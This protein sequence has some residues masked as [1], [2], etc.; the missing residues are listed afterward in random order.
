MPRI[1]AW[2]N[3]HPRQVVNLVSNKSQKWKS[4]AEKY[5]R[6]AGMGELHRFLSA[7]RAQRGIISASS[8]EAVQALER[9]PEG[10]AASAVLVDDD[11]ATCLGNNALAMLCCMQDVY[12]IKGRLS[13]VA[14]RGFMVEFHT[15]ETC[16]MCLSGRVLPACFPPKPLVHMR[17]IVACGWK[18]YWL[19]DGS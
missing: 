14:S 5:N 1:N 17:P 3:Y 6:R 2:P 12:A 10:S 11:T 7:V 16:A 8:F 13:R 19:V 18:C 15:T 9:E 4:A